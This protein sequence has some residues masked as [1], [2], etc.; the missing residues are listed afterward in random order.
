MCFFSCLFNRDGDLPEAKAKAKAEPKAKA[1]AEPKAKAK[2]EPKT[3]AK[4]IFARRDGFFGVRLEY[5]VVFFC[6]L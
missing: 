3:K 6:Q 4:A 1:K 5:T 2:A